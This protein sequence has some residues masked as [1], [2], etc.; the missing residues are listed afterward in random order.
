[1]NNLKFRTK[2]FAAT[3]LSCFK[4]KTSGHSCLMYHSI[5][6]NS[7]QDDIFLLSYE[8]FKDQ[9]SFIGGE[10]TIPFLSSGEGISLTFDDGYL[11]NYTVAAPLLF[12]RNMPFTIF[13]VSDFINPSEKDY[14]NKEHLRELSLNPL[15]TLGAHGKT[16]R[17][18]ASLS[19]QEAKVEMR[20]SKLEL[21]D[22]IGKKVSAMSFPHGSFNQELLDIALELGYEKCGTSIPATNAVPNSGIQVNRHCIYSCESLLS[23]KQK[24]NGQ[25]NWIA[26]RSSSK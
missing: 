15:V 14:L 2:H 5:V 20:I 18:L 11:D 9:I 16:H 24:I 26:K 10:K 3:V 19:L 6:Q 23:L 25:W 4:N 22:I 8:K 13:M 17:P 1:M 12:E 7:R 21:E